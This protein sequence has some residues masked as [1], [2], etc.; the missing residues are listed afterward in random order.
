MSF[1]SQ[2]AP[3]FDYFFELIASGVSERKN[4][5]KVDKMAKKLTGA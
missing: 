2:F 5:R 4:N 1:F 3:D